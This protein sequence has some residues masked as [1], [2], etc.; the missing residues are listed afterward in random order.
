MALAAFI[1]KGEVRCALL[2]FGRL[3]RLGLR[4][5]FGF[6]GSLCFGSLLRLVVSVGAYRHLG[7]RTIVV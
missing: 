6:L 5:L 2:L 3:L 4:L 1:R 7:R